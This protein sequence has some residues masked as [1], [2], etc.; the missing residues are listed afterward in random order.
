[1]QKTP[2]TPPRTHTGLK[3]ASAHG[4]KL[5][6]PTKTN[7]RTAIRSYRRK[8]SGKIS[9]WT[10]SNGVWKHASQLRKEQSKHLVHQEIRAQDQHPVG[11]VNPVGGAEDV[12]QTIGKQIKSGPRTIGTNGRQD[13][14]NSH[15]HGI[16]TEPESQRLQDGTRST[17]RGTTSNEHHGPLI[18]KEN[19]PGPRHRPQVEHIP[20]IGPHRHLHNH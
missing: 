2:L 15:S 5:G 20:A 17:P 12:S 13:G 8:A 7:G 18:L 6:R 19:N 14:S 9:I 1:M 10:T 3:R 11:G 4:H 16:K